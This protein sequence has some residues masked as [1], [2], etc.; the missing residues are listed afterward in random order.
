MLG[1]AWANLAIDELYFRYGEWLSE[2]L[3]DL[4]TTILGSVTA[5]YSSHTLSMTWFPRLERR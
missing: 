4:E 1:D 2:I 5:R 3:G